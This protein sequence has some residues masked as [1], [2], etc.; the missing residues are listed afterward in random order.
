MAKLPISFS[1]KNHYKPRQQMA[2]ESGKKLQ[3]G[4]ITNRLY[5]KSM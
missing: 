5:N 2:F 3:F 4:F 1:K